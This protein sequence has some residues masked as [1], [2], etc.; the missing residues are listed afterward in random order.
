M[1]KIKPPKYSPSSWVLYLNRNDDNLPH[2]ARVVGAHMRHGEW[3]YAVS[4]INAVPHK[5]LTLAE[6]DI[7]GY[8]DDDSSWKMVKKAQE[9]V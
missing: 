3:Q 1:D 4:D 6:N 8:L 9:S 7:I 5:Y 2:T